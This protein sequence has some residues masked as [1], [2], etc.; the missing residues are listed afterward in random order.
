LSSRQLCN[1]IHAIAKIYNFDST[2]LPTAPEKA[3]LSS[4]LEDDRQR[5]HK[6]MGIAEKW[7][8][9]DY[10]AKENVKEGNGKDNLS[11]SSSFLSMTPEQRRLK[12]TVDAI[13]IRLAALSCSYEK[14]KPRVGEAS[15][16]CWAFGTLKHRSR[17][18]GWIMPPQLSQLEKKSSKKDKDTVTFEQWV[19][20]TNQDDYIYSD[21]DEE[22]YKTNPTTQFFDAV[23]MYL[24]EDEEKNGKLSSKVG[25]MTW[26]EIANVAWAFASHGH[27]RSEASEQLMTTLAAEAVFRLEQASAAKVMENN[28]LSS[29]TTIFVNITSKAINTKN[30]ST[31]RQKQH[32][33]KRKTKGKL[34]AEGR[35]SLLT[36]FLPRDISQL[37]WSIGTLQSDNFRLCDDLASVID[38]LA[39]YY[40]GDSST[41]LKPSSGI[42]QSW[43]NTDLVQLG[44]SLGH[45]RIDHQP[46]LITLFQEATRRLH[47]QGSQNNRSRPFQEWEVSVLLWVQARLYLKDIDPIFQQ[48]TSLAS[49]WLRQR[50]SRSSSLKNIGIGDQEKAN[51]AWTLTVLEAYKN[52]DPE[53]TIALLRQIFQEASSSAKTTLIQLEHAHQLWQALFLI[54]HECP[55][56]LIADDGSSVVP[57]EFRKFLED[58]WNDEKARQ[59][60][61]SARHKSLSQTLELMGIAHYNEHDEDIDVAIVL[62]ED[63]SWTSEVS[64]D[65]T[66]TATVTKKVALEFDGPLHFTREFSG[67]QQRTL[68]HTVL[69]YRLLKM[70][71]WAVVRIPYYEF[72]KIPFWASME[73]QRY[74]Q[75]KLK[76]HASLSFSE[77]D[78]SEYWPLSQKAPRE[79]RFD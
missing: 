56:I 74:L 66:A 70:Q 67:Q 17:P 37:V 22:N 54:E 52:D 2:I 26:N 53:D 11:S 58:R 39:L 33:N 10:E 79:S 35:R 6:T 42:L 47:Q 57:N 69:K 20:I 36:T 62:K 50:A 29:E 72:D 48:F 16:A 14:L 59:K 45:G 73:R 40:L 49:A 12:I 28:A 61:S 44:V 25:E 21:Y 8:I 77:K 13:A 9:E 76:T 4:E 32:N 63:A 65:I 27:C 15:M 78:V 34:K 60:I 31:R 19:D 75:R 1:S 68:G 18:P 71:G 38:A 24:S 3:S 7:I 23:A 55:E 64:E 30:N 43:S 46:L 5:R 41:E 51:L